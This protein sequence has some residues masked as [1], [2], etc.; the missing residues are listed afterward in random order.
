[1]LIVDNSEEQ[2]VLVNNPR[3]SLYG[4]NSATKR[5]LIGVE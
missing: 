5:S 2:Y 1:M 3:S 4:V